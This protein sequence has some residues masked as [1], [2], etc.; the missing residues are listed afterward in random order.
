MVILEVEM[1]M[2]TL[3]R[4][5]LWCTIINGAIGVLWG[6]MYFLAPDWMYRMHSKMFPMSRETFVLAN[7]SLIGFFKLMFW[8]FNLTPYIVLRILA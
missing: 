8:L 2:Q 1:D 5:F 4:F 7:Y 6:G 3:T